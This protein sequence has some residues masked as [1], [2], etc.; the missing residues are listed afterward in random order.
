VLFCFFSYLLKKKS[1]STLSPGDLND[2]FSP[3]LVI[4]VAYASGNI[5][6]GEM[7]VLFYHSIAT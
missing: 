6:L 3:S 2:L 5:F 1:T 4:L 7:D